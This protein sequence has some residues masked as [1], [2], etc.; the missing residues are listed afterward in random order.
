MNRHAQA[1]GR[2]TSL[3]L[4]VNVRSMHRLTFGVGALETLRQCLAVLG[5]HVSARPMIFPPVT[6]FSLPL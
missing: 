2:S 3:L 1:C 4:V 6:G 5:N